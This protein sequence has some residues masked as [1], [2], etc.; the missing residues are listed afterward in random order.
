MDRARTGP[1]LRDLQLL[2]FQAGLLLNAGELEAALSALRPLLA[3]ATAQDAIRIS[4]MNDIAYAEGLLGRAEALDEADRFSAEVLATFPWNPSIQNTRGVVL[5]ARGR[6][7]EALPL[8]RGSAESAA[9]L[10]DHQAQRHSVLAMAEASQGNLSAAERSLDIA[11]QA[12]PGCS[13]LARAE[14]AVSGARGLSLP[15][16]GAGFQP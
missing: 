8:L 14:A 11:R 4:L 7:E 16:D 5:F 1:L 12:Q 3:R 2:G 6:V 9:E 15:E 13:L 10:P